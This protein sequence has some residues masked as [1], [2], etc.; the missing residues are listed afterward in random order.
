MG[1]MTAPE[2]SFWGLWQTLQRCRHAGLSWPD[3]QRE[4]AFHPTRAWRLDFAWE[5][6]MVAVE[7][8]GAIFTGGR[9]SRGAG[10]A[11]DATKYNEAV[12]LGWAVIRLTDK[13]LKPQPIRYTT[14]GKQKAGSGSN[15]VDLFEQIAKLIA[16]R[17][18]ILD[19]SPGLSV[20]SRPP[21]QL[22]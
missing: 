12:F 14:K 10:L 16:I 21:F 18:R 4:V 15:P 5:S 2:A 6:A 3:P 13:Q 7:I 22:Q 19:G 8:E 20:G 11:E 9:H 1:K 17:T